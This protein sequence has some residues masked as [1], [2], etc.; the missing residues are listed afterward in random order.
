[1]RLKPEEILKELREHGFEEAWV[2]STLLLPET[3]RG[4]PLAGEGKPHPVSELVQRLRVAFLE[5][6]FDEVLLPTIIEE[7]EIYKQYGS[8]API[9]LDRCYY[10]AVLPR[11]DIGLSNEKCSRIRSMGIY[12]DNERIDALQHL[13]R[14]YKLGRVEPDDLVEKIMEGLG[15][16]DATAIKVIREVF[17]EFTSLRPSPSSLTLRSH[18]TSAWF[19]TLSILQHRM[20]RPIKLF[21]VGVRF[22]REQ[23]EDATH[24]RTHFGASC[25]ILDEEVTVED[26]KC[27]VEEVF[28]RLGI[29]DSKLSRKKTTSKYYAPG[30]EYELFVYAPKFGKWIEVANL[31]LYSPIALAQY[32]IEFPVLNLGFGVERLGM[33]IYGEEDVRVLAYPQFYGKWTM[34]D[35]E[36]ARMIRIK[37]TPKTPEGERIWRAI[38]RTAIS[39]AER[40]SPCEVLAFEGR[41]LDRNVRVTI[42]ETDENTKLIGPA[43]L[44]TVYVYDGNVL[45]IPAVGMENVKLVKEARERGKSTG[46]TF[47]DAVAAYA[48]YRIELEAFKPVPKNF[49][50]R[51]RMAKLPSDVNIGLSDVANRYI[52]SRQRK[53]IIKG[54]VFI[55]VRAYFL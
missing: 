36:L 49:E 27:I 34:A 13:L 25:V 22:R 3:G 31:G 52:T 40:P 12:L 39:E 33:I 17:P 38:V 48:A 45:G 32:D 15:A 2:R 7:G 50:H 14:D 44:N 28:R 55:G 51:V 29:K 43:A 1:L 37:Q 9:I 35:A 21:S 30:S 47:L 20:P 26:G 46:I 8:E 42:Y 41:I 19:D 10:L 16:S 11:P 5:I 18:I 6:G 23:S 4:I 53:V 54:P 24:L